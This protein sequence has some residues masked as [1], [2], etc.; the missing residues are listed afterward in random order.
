MIADDD[1]ILMADEY[2][3]QFYGKNFKAV[4]FTHGW[5]KLVNDLVLDRRSTFVFTMAGC[6]T[7]EVYV[8]NH[9]TGTEI[10]FKKVE[11]VVLDDSIYGDD[12][13]DFLITVDPK[14][15]AKIVGD[16]RLPSKVDPRG[17]SN[18]V[19]CDR[20]VSSKV[21]ADKVRRM[22][23]V[24]E[25]S[26]SS[27]KVDLHNFVVLKKKKKAMPKSKAVRS[28]S[29]NSHIAFRTRLNFSN[30]NECVVIDIV[31]P[32]ENITA[33]PKRKACRSITP[34]ADVV[35]RKCYTVKRLKTN[36]FFEFTKMAESKLRL[37]GEVAS[38]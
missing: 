34:M 29:E 36:A 10:Q 7:F 5:S 3:R 6:K 21:V 8:F 22:P 11:L 16:K 2:W 12:G 26:K 25:T 30:N 9:Q 1:V 31:K 20:S 28:V 14:G 24:E 18:V 23:L 15:K 32:A 17:K 27:S 19:V 33:K 4:F 35:G 37:L 38:D 13:Y